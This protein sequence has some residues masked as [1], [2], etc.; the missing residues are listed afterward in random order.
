MGEDGYLGVARGNLDD[1]PVTFTKWYNDGSKG[2]FSQPGLGGLDS[3]VTPIR[4]CETTKYTGEYQTEGQ[5]SYLTAINQY[6]LTFVCVQSI[7]GIAQQAGW[8][9]STASSLELQNWTTPVLITGSQQ[10]VTP[11]TNGGDSFDGW[12]PS[13]MSPNHR[14]GHLGKTGQVFFPKGV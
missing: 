11:C 14:A 2:S 8:Y 7:D 13:F 4:G 12:Y 5:I 10:T 6:L 1:T 3:G 9:Y